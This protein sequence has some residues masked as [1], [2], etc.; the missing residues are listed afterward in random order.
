MA[1]E[2]K[3][4]TREERISAAFDVLAA[5][6]WKESEACSAW[7]LS[8]PDSPE[9]HDRMVEW[10]QAVAELER[11]ELAFLTISNVTGATDG[12]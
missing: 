9:R 2:T 12:E 1:S 5:A 7:A 11:A 4:T 8:A 6:E 3:T 10:E